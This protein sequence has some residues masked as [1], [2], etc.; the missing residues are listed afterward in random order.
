MKTSTAK[1]S[2]L[3]SLSRNAM[4]VSAVAILTACG[5]DDAIQEIG[6]AQLYE[7]GAE[8]LRGNNYAGAIVSFRNLS[9]R[10]PFAPQARQAQLDLLYAFYRAGQYEEAIDIA[11]TF[12]RENPRLPEVAYCLYMQGMIYF[13]KEPN[14]LER[15]FRVDIT[16]RP[17]KETYLAFTAFQDL[18]R[19]FPDSAYVADSRQRMIYLRNRLATYENHVARYYLSRGAYVAAMQRAKY[20]IEHYPGAPQLEETLALLIEAYDS[21]GMRDLADDTRRVL[22]QSFGDSADEISGA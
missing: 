17:P 6:A 11:E 7:Q 16:E 3:T 20:A 12:I 19:Q 5:G 10:Y 2:P 15:L 1:L 18:I 8:Q 4:L 13:D 9:I 14:V 22:Q 21:L